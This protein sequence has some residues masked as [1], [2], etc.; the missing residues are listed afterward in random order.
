MNFNVVNAVTELSTYD[1]LHLR[2][3]SALI[4]APF[5]LLFCYIDERLFFVFVTLVA[6]IC[7]YEWCSIIFPSS[8]TL[9]TI[10]SVFLTL[11]LMV[12]FYVVMDPWTGVVFVWILGTIALL[13]H[14]CTQ[15]YPSAQLYWIIYGFVYINSGLL[16]VLWLRHTDCGLFYIGFLFLIVWTMD[17]ASFFFGR[18]LKGPL[19]APR[20][21]PR[22]TWAGYV[23]GLCVSILVTLGGYTFFGDMFAQVHVFLLLFLTVILASLTQIGDLF[24]SGVKRRFEIKDS[25]TFIPGHGGLLDRVD[26]LLASA[27]LLAVL[28]VFFVPLQEISCI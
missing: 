23:G 6:V 25:G 17:S 18:L 22:K 14:L 2:F 5:V 4:L 26:G 27:Q 10:I 16:A 20:W 28:T 1:N 11:V 7:T 21:S 12:Y 13:L 24:L 9:Y 15:T 3:L 19:L 8:L